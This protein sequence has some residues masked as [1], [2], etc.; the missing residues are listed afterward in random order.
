VTD[1]AKV[2]LINRSYSDMVL[3][4]GT[5]IFRHGRVAREIGEGLRLRRDHP[6]LAAGAAAQPNFLQ[7]GRTQRC[8]R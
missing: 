7:R 5:T 6:A 2:A 8:D 4:Y 1:N 3:H